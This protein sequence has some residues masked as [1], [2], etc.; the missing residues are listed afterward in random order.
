[1]RRAALLVF[2]SLTAVAAAAPPEGRWTGNARLPNRDLPLVVDLAQD[3][4]GAWNGSL[5]IPG[6]N[7]KGAELS[8]V[9]LE[10]RDIAFDAASVLSPPTGGAGVAFKARIEGAAIVGEMRQAGN[11]APFRLERTGPAQV[12]VAARSTPVAGSTQGRWV[13]QFELG[14]YPRDVTLDIANEGSA[15][16]RVEFIVVGKQ[17][18][19]LPIDFVAEEEGIL[20]IESRPYGTTLEA[21]VAGDRI[22]GTLEVGA[23]E[24]PIL[25]RR[26]V[27]KKS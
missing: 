7:I 14:G 3:K 16:P 17:T 19:R 5:T 24:I 9:A 2:L 26:S 18:T 8:H 11:V 15:K 6:Q 22:E 21:R 10:G 20:R 1:M 25:L 13:G 23:T 4:S 27:E 12:D